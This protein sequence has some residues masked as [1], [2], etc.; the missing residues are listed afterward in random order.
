MVFKRDMTAAADIA[1]R[2]AAAALVLLVVA[3]PPHAAHAKRKMFNIFWNASNP[4]FRID[5]TDHVIDINEDNLPWEYDQANII[6][7]VY[8]P[9]SSDPQKERYV[10]YSV[11]RDEFENCRIVNPN[12]KVVLVCNRPSELAYVTITFRSFTPTPGGLEFKPGQDYYFIS[13]SSRGDLH[14]R[15]GGGCS[16]HNMRLVF[17]IAPSTGSSS[18][19]EQAHTQPPAA[20]PTR[21]RT[22]SPLEYQGFLYPSRDVAL[23]DDNSVD[24]RDAAFG[25]A[26][27]VVKQAS[28]MPAASSDAVKM[29]VNAFWC[30]C[31]GL[32]LYAASRI[33]PSL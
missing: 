17:K 9:D 24:G 8:G 29:R 2:L 18:S 16:A 28:V 31:A 30:A 14:Q 33:L 7:P 25:S 5:T 10:I 27:E 23:D 4:I 20:A 21:G 26:G 13:T 6:C 11:S 32:W 3:A 22:K 19:A 15:V 1:R 12:P